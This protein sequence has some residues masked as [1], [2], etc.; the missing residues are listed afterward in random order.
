MQHC[1]RL[2]VILKIWN[3][4]LRVRVTFSS[5]GRGGGGYRPPIGLSTKMKNKK[6]NT[7]LA[8]L[9]LVFALEWTKK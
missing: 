1:K 2:S 6:N 4:M 5:L 9:K 7:F 8:L 3:V